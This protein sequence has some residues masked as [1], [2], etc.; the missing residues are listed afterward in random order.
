VS[1]IYA[2]GGYINSN[3][4]DYWSYNLEDKVFE[5]FISGLFHENSS[6]ALF[7]DEESAK[8]YQLTTVEPKSVFVKKWQVLF[9][10]ELKHGVN[11][12]YIDKL[13]K[14]SI[15]TT[16]GNPVEIKLDYSL[17]S[18]KNL[19]SNSD[20]DRLNTFILCNEDLK[21]SPVKLL[22]E[23]SSKIFDYYQ[24]LAFFKEQT[25]ES[26]AKNNSL[27]EIPINFCTIF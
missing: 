20:I 27:V 8:K 4:E 7:P 11:G 1:I 21:D 22:P 18:N 10:V 3:N 17:P 25:P 13:I 2:V 6:L 5:S 26:K 9:E 19:L 24:Q 14:A 23:I 12:S 15:M 16:S